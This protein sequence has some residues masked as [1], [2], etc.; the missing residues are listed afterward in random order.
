MSDFHDISVIIPT[1]NRAQILPRALDSVLAQSFAPQEIIVVDDGSGDDTELLLRQK[2]P[3]VKYHFQPNRGVSSA[4]NLGVR[5]C[6]G[7]WIAFLDS[8]DEWLPDK[9]SQ[10]VE[11]LRAIP[12]NLFCHTDEIWIRNGQRVNPM[13]KHK[14][15]GGDIFLHCLPMCVISPSSVL[16]DKHLFVQSGGFNESLP[17]CEDYDLWLRICARESVAFVNQPLL[18]KYGGHEDQ[19]SK[20]YWGMDR[21]RV[22]ALIGILEAGVLND[23][24]ELSA[25]KVLEKKCLIL[26]NGALKRGH[27]QRAD[28]YFQAASRYAVLA[29]VDSCGDANGVEST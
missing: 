25:K 26:A 10:Q 15:T 27:Q 22:K 2:Y 1:L 4:R 18:R 6:N 23:V 7:K 8:D 9:L 5:N 3:Q 16:M 29:P 24:Q 28:N 20:R 19:L 11:L 13:R 21:F 17:A 14:K 12:G